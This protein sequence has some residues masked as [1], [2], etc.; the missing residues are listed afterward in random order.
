MLPLI[1]TRFIPNQTWTRVVLI[2]AAAL[3]GL[4][5]IYV[6][7]FIVDQADK[8]Q[9]FGTV[10]TFIYFSVVSVGVLLFLGGTGYLVYTLYGRQK[11]KEKR[12]E[13]RDKSPSE[14]NARERTTQIRENIAEIDRVQAN[15]ADDVRQQLRPML[16]TFGEKQTAQRLEI[17]A[18]GSISCGKSSLLNAL[19]GRQVFATDVRGG[20]TL[21]RS[22]IQW[23]GDQHVLLVDTPGLGEIDGAEHVQEAA[24]AAQNAD[25]VLLVVDGPLRD[26]EH[27]L[28][29]VLHRM[30]KRLLICLNK[31]DWYS[32]EDQQRLRE[33][34]TKQTE[35]AVK[36]EDV[37]TVQASSGYRLRYRVSL[38]GTT[39]EEVV[40][41]PASID[42]L[43]K[44]LR[45]TVR[46]DGKDLLLANLLLQSRS[47]LDHAKQKAVAAL[48]QKAMAIVDS[49]ALGAGTVAALPFPIVDIA[50]GVAINTKMV[51]D[52]AKVYD[53]QIDLSSASLLLGKLATNLIGIVGTTAVVGGISSLLKTVPGINLAGSLVQACVQLLITRWIGVVFMEYFKNEMQEPEG[54]LAGLAQREW[55]RMTT[56]AELKKL[57]DMARKNL[58]SA[59]ST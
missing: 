21:R 31:A 5:L 44:R 23:P 50:A 6:P 34:L 51:V 28:I 12:L 38:S 49:W 33:Q 10:W 16:D 42:H 8:V 58:T 19:A 53:Q 17:V 43:T 56:M 46:S 54:G 14:L 57:V 13:R 45:E 25:V 48:D 2:L 1:P 24:N 37:L 36:L 4:L 26:S 20:T 29:Q 22:D 40:P 11:S 35:E 52:L 41:L 9:Q 47:L 59:S 32:A 55:K 39:T 18:F 30:E 15:L 3:F 7:S 27:R